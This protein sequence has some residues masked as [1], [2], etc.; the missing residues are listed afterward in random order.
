M[1]VLWSIISMELFEL[2]LSGD[3]EMPGEPE[4]SI[5]VVKQ[6]SVRLL[7]AQ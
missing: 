4:M 6:V 5:W 1:L 2:D 3:M 7:L